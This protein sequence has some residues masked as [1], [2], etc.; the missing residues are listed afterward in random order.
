MKMKNVKFSDELFYV[1]LFYDMTIKNMILTN[2]RS[3]FLE[4]STFRVFFF[5]TESRIPMKCLTALE[6]IHKSSL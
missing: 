6:Y 4:V 3:F 5:R 2:Q 1:K